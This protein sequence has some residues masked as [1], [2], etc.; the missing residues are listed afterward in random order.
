MNEESVG[1]NLANL[2]KYSSFLTYKDLCCFENFGKTENNI[3][4]AEA[5]K[6][7]RYQPDPSYFFLSY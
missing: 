6:V 4:S 1:W 7:L 3:I 2:P 5:E